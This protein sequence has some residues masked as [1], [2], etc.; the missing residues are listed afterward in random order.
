MTPFLFATT[1]FFYLSLFGG[2][3]DVGSNAR[4]DLPTN[5]ISETKFI[6]LE[7]KKNDVLSIKLPI[8]VEFDCCMDS[9]NY[10]R[11]GADLNLDLSK[12]LCCNSSFIFSESLDALITFDL[13]YNGDYLHKTNQEF[14]NHF[15]FTHDGIMRGMNFLWSAVL[16]PEFSGC[17]PNSPS[18]LSNFRGVKYEYKSTIFNSV[19]AEQFFPTEI[20]YCYIS[21]LIFLLPIHGRGANVMCTYV[22][23]NPKVKDFMVLKSIRDNFVI[24]KLNIDDSYSIYFLDKLVELRP[25]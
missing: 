11:F 18:L 17:T 12:F 5:Q 24:E 25:E 23:L 3:I 4:Q 19:L 6:F 13:V 1:T 22:S 16:F 2:I 15:L 7:V 10:A 8:P 14:I 20:G 21:Q 9:S